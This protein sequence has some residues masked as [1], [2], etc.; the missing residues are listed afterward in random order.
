MD[1][2]LP[3]CS[4]SNITNSSNN[5]EGRLRSLI[6]TKPKLVLH[7]KMMKV[8]MLQEYR[9]KQQDI[10]NR[11]LRQMTY[12]GRCEDA[13]NK[14]LESSQHTALSSEVRRKYL[15]QEC[16]SILFSGTEQNFNNNRTIFTNYP[17]AAAVV[18]PRY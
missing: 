18:E 12:P 13:K 10:Y 1:Y 5:V 15:P 3:S 7:N 6:I 17:I 9:N 8:Q 11:H 4:S 16:D 14:K 2:S